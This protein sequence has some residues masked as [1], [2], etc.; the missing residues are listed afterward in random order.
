MDSWGQFWRFIPPCIWNRFT[1]ILKSMIWDRCFESSY[2]S[3]NPVWEQEKRWQYQLYEM[4]Q[5]GPRHSLGV[6][7]IEVL[8]YLCCLRVEQCSLAQL[9]RE[10]PWSYWDFLSL[11]L[12]NRPAEM[13]ILFPFSQHLLHLNMQLINIRF[14]LTLESGS[15]S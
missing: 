6:L 3:L 11:W 2:F 8:K 9:R 4:C 7:L 1:I 5:N 14:N 12:P 13:R 10:N 15:G